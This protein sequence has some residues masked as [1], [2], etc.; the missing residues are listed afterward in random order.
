[1][2]L[3]LTDL[4]TGFTSTLSQTTYRA[5]EITEARLCVPGIPECEEFS[6]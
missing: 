6:A 5:A 4:L 3:F 2:A 1:M